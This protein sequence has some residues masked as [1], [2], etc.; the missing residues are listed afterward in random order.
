MAI[1]YGSAAGG[2]RQCPTPTIH[3]LRDGMAPADHRRQ[4]RS[5]RS[6][7]SGSATRHAGNDPLISAEA[8][9]SRPASSPPPY[10]PARLGAAPPIRPARAG[11]H[12]R[13][14]R[15]PTALPMATS[16]RQRGQ[17]QPSHGPST[18]SEGAQS[19]LSALTGPEWPSAPA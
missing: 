7:G 13:S 11:T 6:A 17:G 12:P 19:A 1:A 15:R 10:R 16:L 5:P 9:P 3:P 18:S 8:A 2:H 14:A 4:A